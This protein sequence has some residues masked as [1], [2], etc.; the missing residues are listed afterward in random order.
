MESDVVTV[1][2]ALAD[3]DPGPADVAGARAADAADAGAPGADACCA[4][5]AG[6]TPFGDVRAHAVATNAAPIR[7]AILFTI[8]FP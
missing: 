4:T 6:A 5:G 8:L 3:I 2:A 7:T 1:A